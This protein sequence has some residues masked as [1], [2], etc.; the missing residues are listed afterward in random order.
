MWKI[1][2]MEK[3]MTGTTN[4][5]HKINTQYLRVA[6]HNGHN[7]YLKM[8]E[9]RSAKTSTGHKRYRVLKCAQ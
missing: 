4:S 3:P 5:N 1:I 2:D 6:W 7:A 9:F 8:D